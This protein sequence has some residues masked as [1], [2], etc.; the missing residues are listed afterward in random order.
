MDKRQNISL[1][2]ESSQNEIFFSD[3]IDF[4][5]ILKIHI[6][7]LAGKDLQVQRFKKKYSKNQ[8]KS[9]QNKDVIK[10]RYHKFHLYVDSQAL[11]QIH[12][13]SNLSL[14]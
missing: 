14:F 13:F 2:N 9:F 4:E 7:I 11:N 10:F 5:K 12:F 1:W 8:I 6:P 3:M